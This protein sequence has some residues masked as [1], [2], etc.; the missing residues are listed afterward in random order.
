MKRAFPD[1]CVD[2][3]ADLIADLDNDPKDRHVAAAA[4]NA[5]AAAIV[6][7]NLDDF[8]SNQL[9]AGDIEVIT[10]GTLVE[11][12]LDEAPEIVVLEARVA[13]AKTVHSGPNLIETYAKLRVDCWRYNPGL[14]STSSTRSAPSRTFCSRTTPTPRA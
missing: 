7:D 9:A 14:C 3:P 6:T 8:V 5:G 10:P 12:L 4:L 2:V 13:A 1:A 11:R